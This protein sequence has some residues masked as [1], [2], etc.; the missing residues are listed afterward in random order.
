MR[1]EVVGEGDVVLVLI[2]IFRML[3]WNENE[4]GVGKV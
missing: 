2:V 1:C 4:H 3:L